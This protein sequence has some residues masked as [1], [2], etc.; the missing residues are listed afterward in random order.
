MNDIAYHDIFCIYH[1]ADIAFVRRLVAQMRASGIDCWFDDSDFGK[2]SAESAQLKAGLLQAFTVAIV[3]TQSS[4]ESQLCN[5]LIQH[6][7]THRK[8]IITLIHDDNINVEVHPAIISNTYLYFR[9]QDNLVEQIEQLRPHLAVDEDLRLQTK[10]LVAAER[11]RASGRKQE[12]LLPAEHWEEARQWLADANKRP[13]KP[14]QLQVEFIHSSRRQRSS[15]KRSRA[16]SRARW[17]IWLLVALMLV[18]VGAIALRFAVGAITSR[19][20]DAAQTQSAL[21]YGAAT[22]ASEGAVGLIDQLAAT[23][24]RLSE[25]VGATASAATVAAIEARA[26]AQARATSARATQAH[27][28]M[29]S[30]DGLRLLDAAGQALQKGETDLAL[31]LAWEAQPA[32]ADP[33]AA[34][35]LLRLIAAELN[36]IDLGAGGRL[37]VRGDGEAFALLTA[38]NMLQIRDTHGGRLLEE[39]HAQPQAISALAYSPAGDLLAVGKDNGEIVIRNDSQTKRRIAAHELPVSAVSFV[40]N[41]RLLS[42]GGEPRL[43]LWDIESGEQLAKLDEADGWTIARLAS[44]KHS[45][46]VFGWSADGRELAQWSSETLDALPLAFALRGVDPTGRI[47]YS[48]GRTLP[49]VP[50]DPHVSELIFWDLQSGE[51][52]ARIGSLDELATT[53][54]LLRIDEV[55]FVAFGDDNALIVSQGAT[56]ERNATL[57]A[58]AD[59]QVIKRYATN[60]A[61]RLQSAQYLAEDVW[62]SATRQ[63]GLLW[64]SSADGQIIHELGASPA[65]DIVAGARPGTA[66]AAG[67]LLLVDQAGLQLRQL[68]ADDESKKLPASLWAS[69]GEFL[70]V[71]DGETA[72]IQTARADSAIRSWH[73]PLEGLQALYP[74]ADGSALV[75]VD[76][77]IMWLLQA[78]SAA[79]QALGVGAA[80]LPREVVFA[81]D[82]R[83][84]VSLHAEVLLLWDAQ[85][86]STLAAFPLGLAADA[87]AAFHD[88]ALVVYVPLG[89]GL[90][91]LTRLSLADYTAQRHVLVDVR[92]GALA[93][94]GAALALAKSDG[95]IVLHDT[96]DGR[97]RRRMAGEALEVSKLA[98]LPEAGRLLAAVGGELRLWHGESGELEARFAH[99]L[100]IVDFS[101]SPAARHFLTRDADD[102]FRLWQL[103]HID[104]LLARIES[105]HLPRALTCAER[106]QFNARP[107]CL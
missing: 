73:A 74:A 37:Q 24:A 22:V 25:S 45:E 41:D 18:A 91:A 13:I 80:G 54:N 10:L 5:E 97:L 99:A 79:P 43:A 47:G 3:L 98:I 31:A 11:W 63:G 92:M 82:G 29:R 62:L 17:L 70:A 8:R 105:D 90:A 38:D 100:P 14:T 53:D 6:A 104:S 65:A 101:Y 9:E 88:D 93:A 7:V 30:S 33:G 4:A 19:Q 78:D 28:P 86:A 102:V 69:A 61:A 55:L 107:L 85:D 52:I 23:S 68:A 57:V 106:E 96:T 83:R 56:G 2:L 95:S 87:Q 49:A 20:A 35:R 15:G 81:A 103:E 76:E 50:D 51:A 1:P 72:S 59:G 94:D 40:A 42:A 89:E 39:W 34:H 66:L 21:G 46:S 58:I 75:A 27:L 60:L 77:R 36:S 71:H 26:T 16:S 64:W 48:G 44:A 67:G 12:H 84:F 32:L